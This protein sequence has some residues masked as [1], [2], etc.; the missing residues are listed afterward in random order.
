MV[1]LYCRIVGVTIVQHND[2]GTEQRHIELTKTE[3][4]RVMVRTNINKK[5]K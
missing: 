2:N 3:Q 5:I 1:G 4:F